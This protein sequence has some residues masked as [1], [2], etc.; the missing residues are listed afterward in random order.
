VHS[1]GSALHLAL[2]SAIANMRNLSNDH[3]GGR[4][5]AHYQDENFTPSRRVAMTRN[6]QRD[7]DAGYFE[8]QGMSL[9]A[10]PGADSFDERVA[11]RKLGNL[12]SRVP[13]GRLPHSTPWVPAGALHQSQPSV[14]WHRQ[15]SVQSSLA[16][17]SAPFL[18]LAPPQSPQHQESPEV[19]TRTG[20]PPQRRQPGIANS[21]FWK[22]VEGQAERE[23]KLLDP[24]G[25]FE[26]KGRA[27]VDYAER[28]PGAHLIRFM[29]RAEPP[30]SELDT[31]VEAASGEPDV[32]GYRA[33][34]LRV[35]AGGHLAISWSTCAMDQS[36]SAV[37]GAPRQ[38]LQSRVEQVNA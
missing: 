12:S 22:I 23:V 26:I 29:F 8:G 24:S 3:C 1:P 21:E 4:F 37:A 38:E 7:R 27:Q 18:K 30:A 28:L 13:M 6:S 19:I 20:E 5:G 9:L 31:T 25:K 32:P 2:S 33:W 16:R 15:P 34:A 14:S 36:Q 10:P 11:N 17:S 35:L